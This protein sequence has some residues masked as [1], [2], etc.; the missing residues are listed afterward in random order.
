MLPCTVVECSAVS[1]DII[2]SVKVL[3]SMAVHC[4]TY[5]A[6]RLADNVCCPLS[7]KTSWLKWTQDYIGASA[8]FDKAGRFSVVK[9]NCS[10]PT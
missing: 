2:P 1:I 5:T 8:A 9:V 3:L 7:L 10:I 6:T 4:T